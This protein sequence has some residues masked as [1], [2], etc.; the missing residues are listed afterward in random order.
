MTDYHRQH[1][2]KFCREYDVA[3]DNASALSGSLSLG[4]AGDSACARLTLTCTAL[5]SATLDVTLEGCDGNPADENAVWYTLGAFTQM[6]EAGSE[7][8]CFP[9]ARHLRV[10]SDAAEEFGDVT[11]D[12][13]NGVLTAITQDVGSGPGFT[14]AKTGA[15]VVGDE[16]VVE[17]TTSGV[18]GTAEFRW[19]DDDG[20]TWIEETVPVPTT[21][22]EYVLTG[23]NITL[24]WADD[25]FVD[26]DVFSFDA[27]DGGTFTVA[28]TPE[29]ENTLGDS[30]VTVTI[31]TAG[32]PGTAEFD[33]ALDG[34]EQ[35]TGVSIPT[36]PFEVELTAIGAT[37]TFEDEEFSDGDEFSFAVEGA[38]FAVVG[39]TV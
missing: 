36:T 4:E 32:D 7:R 27:V 33:W 13:S 9:C 25:T 38:A 3:A 10:T 19:S 22:F 28:G 26:N 30:V 20:A 15:L 17:I 29:G 24:T 5:A 31:S 35:E 11:H 8:K 6:T 1:D 23:K 2:G 39:S 34:V 14:A 21:P 16:Y 12:T 18:N 37:L